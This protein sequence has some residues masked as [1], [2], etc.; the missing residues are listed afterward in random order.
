MFD[1]ISRWLEQA[2]IYPDDQETGL[3]TRTAHF[4][5]VSKETLLVRQGLRSGRIFFVNEG[6]LRVFTRH[7]NQETTLGFVTPP[8]FVSAIP[9]L[10]ENL[11]A[12]FSIQAVTKA[13]VLY[14]GEDELAEIRKNNPSASAIERVAIQQ[15]MRQKEERE[16]SLL[17][18]SPEARYLQ[19]MAEKPLIIQQVP[20]KYIASYLGIQ[21][22]SLSRLRK[23]LSTRN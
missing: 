20:L 3:Y 22:E 23:K 16:M 14:W 2:S 18:Q 9:A 17:T 19:L 7:Q 10:W 13:G 1:S 6:I 4:L 21:A 11:P 5:S 12:T 15:L 8:A